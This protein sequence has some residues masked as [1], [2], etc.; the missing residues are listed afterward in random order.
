M[1]ATSLM[2]LAN[3]LSKYRMWD[4]SVISLLLCLFD[5]HIIVKLQSTKHATLHRTNTAINKAQLTHN[6]CRSTLVRAVDWQSRVRS[7][8]HKAWHF[9]N[10][11]I[12][13]AVIFVLAG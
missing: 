12:I 5:H 10:Y 9:I 7:Y 13:I 8:G 4:L 11:I 2:L 3:I 1:V 6:L